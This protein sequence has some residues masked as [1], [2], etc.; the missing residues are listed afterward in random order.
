MAKHCTGGRTTTGVLI[1]QETANFQTGAF[2]SERAK[3][4]TKDKMFSCELDDGQS[5]RVRTQ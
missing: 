5:V 3:T 4:A 1:S 2:E